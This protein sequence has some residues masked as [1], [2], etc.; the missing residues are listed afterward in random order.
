LTKIVQIFKRKSKEVPLNLN[1]RMAA[2]TDDELFKVLKKRIYYTEEAA[3]IAIEEAKRRGLI[4]S[5]YDL[6]SDK[7]RAEELEFSWFPLP[8]SEGARQRIRKSIGRSLVICGIIPIVFGFLE[9]NSG[10]VGFGRIILAFGIVC[11]VLSTQ[12]ARAYQK[13]LFYGLMVA[14]AMAFVFVCSRVFKMK[15]PVILDFF[16]ALTVFLM[17]AYG[18]LYI[19]RIE[20]SNES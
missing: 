18:L 1:D 8:E 14:N 20:L 16:V 11:G 6:L 13:L 10:S 5:E 17:I 15:T 2:C 3:R 19:R 12:F 9:I 4:N 7:F